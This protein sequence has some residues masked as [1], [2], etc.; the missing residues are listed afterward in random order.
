MSANVAQLLAPFSTHQGQLAGLKSHPMNVKA[1]SVRTGVRM[2]MSIGTSRIKMRN[3]GLGRVAGMGQVECN[4][5]GGVVCRAGVE[6]VV[7]DVELGGGGEGGDGEDPPVL[8][9]TGEED[10]DGEGRAILMD[11]LIKVGSQGS[12]C[13][14]G[15]CRIK[16]LFMVR[17]VGGWVG[18]MKIM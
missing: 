13:V 15:G 14:M 12:L 10:K 7:Q 8:K 16:L 9:D 17:S 3:V 11:A 1:A 4:V 18:V 2:K 5:G 6:E